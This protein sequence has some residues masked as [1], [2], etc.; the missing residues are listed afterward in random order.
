[1]PT[2]ATNMVFKTFHPS[3]L[4]EAAND[5][6]KLPPPP[7]TFA[8]WAKDNPYEAE[9]AAPLRCYKD[10]LGSVPI[11]RRFQS[12]WTQTFA[13]GEDPVVLKG[14]AEV[15]TR[16]YTSKTEYSEAVLERYMRMRKMV[17][18]TPKEMDDIHNL[19]FSKRRKHWHNFSRATRNLT[20]GIPVCGERRI[21]VHGKQ[22]CVGEAR[23]A[24]MR[25]IAVMRDKF[26]NLP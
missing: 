18:T 21:F 23:Y 11:Y 13:S 8:E 17:V 25:S 6:V 1:M 16:A 12:A 7:M 4:T 15:R 14:L 5:L 22:V 10:S 24:M 26:I 2:P 3:L 20:A 19:V 9:I